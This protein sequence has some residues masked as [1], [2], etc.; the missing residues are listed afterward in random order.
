M[1][2]HPQKRKWSLANSSGWPWRR[3]IKEEQDWRMIQLPNNQ[4]GHGDG[5]R[6]KCKTGEDGSY[7]TAQVGIG[8][9]GR[10]KSKKKRNGFD[11]DLIWI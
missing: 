7:H 5:R 3:K 11:L 6:K 10:K 8:D 4:V 1:S 9:R 2:D